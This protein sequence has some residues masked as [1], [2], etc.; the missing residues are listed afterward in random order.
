MAVFVAGGDRNW[1]ARYVPQML[2]GTARI[3]LNNLEPGS[4]RCWTDFEEAFKSN[5]ATTYRR[6]NWS[7][8]L[9]DCKQRENETDRDWLTRWT[10]TRNSCEGVVDAQAISWFANGCRHGSML[11]QRVRRSMPTTLAET[12]R[13]A[14]SHALGDPTQPAPYEAPAPCEVNNGAGPS[15]RLD[16]PDFRNKRNPERQEYRYN[17]VA[18]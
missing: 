12:I 11:W 6:P 18:A 3:W 7:Q 8:Q 4:I 2:E 5:F 14:D 9:A 17:H 1:A 10:Q 15:R 13:I 16:R